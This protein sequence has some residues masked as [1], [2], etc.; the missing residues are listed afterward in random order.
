MSP[1]AKLL[2]V[3]QHQSF[4]EAFRSG[5]FREVDCQLEVV[6][7]ISRMQS[8][9]QEETFNFVLCSLILPDTY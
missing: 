7:S 8:R 3:D 5:L 2:L 6:S 4:I 9:L 1:K